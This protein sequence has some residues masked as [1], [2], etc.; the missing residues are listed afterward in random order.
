ML[1]RFILCS[2]LAL[3]GCATTKEYVLTGNLSEQYADTASKVVMVCPFERQVPT[4]AEIR[5]AS[6]RHKILPKQP[7]EAPLLG[8]SGVLI[9]KTG[10][11]LTANH[12]VRRTPVV[13]VRLQDGR[14]YR[15][16]VVAHDAILDLALLKPVFRL[17]AT[18]SCAKLAVNRPYG[19]PV[20]ALG[21]PDF[22]TEIISAGVL[23][24]EDCDNVVLSSVPRYVSDAVIDFG[25][26]GG[27]L[28]DAETGDLLGITIQVY[29]SYSFSVMTKDIKGFLDKNM[30]LTKRTKYGI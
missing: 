1:K 2:L 18:L 9:S 24:G 21:N 27:G 17:N 25:S 5:S 23:A 12:V 10:L 29:K 13:V 7:F 30:A 4:L 28:F 19:W 11:V 8:S 6:R 20:Y 26:S 3:T 22:M 16:V 15:A 14:S